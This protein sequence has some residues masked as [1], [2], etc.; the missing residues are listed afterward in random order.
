MIGRYNPCLEQEVGL[1]VPEQHTVTDSSWS[2]L[3]QRLKKSM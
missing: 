3:E 2:M 1:V